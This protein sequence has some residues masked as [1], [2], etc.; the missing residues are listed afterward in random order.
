MAETTLARSRPAIEGACL[1]RATSSASL[2]SSLEI[3]ALI[4]PVTRSLRVMAR[5]STP[6]MATMPERFRKSGRLSAERKFEG[7][8]QQLRITKP[9]TWALSLSMSCGVMP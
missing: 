8:S 7:T 4:T 3:T 1:A 5:V 9:L 6:S 2:A